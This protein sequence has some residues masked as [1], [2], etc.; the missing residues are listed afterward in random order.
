MIRFAGKLLMLFPLYA[1]GL[2]VFS[3]ISGAAD[4]ME[5]AIQGQAK[6]ICEAGLMVKCQ[7]RPVSFL[8]Y[9]E[10]PKQVVV[11]YQPAKGDVRSFTI[12]SP[13]GDADSFSEPGSSPEVQKEMKRLGIELKPGDRLDATLVLNSATPLF[14]DADAKQKLPSDSDG[15][16]KNSGSGCS[17]TYRIPRII[18]FNNK[19]TC[20]A[21]IVCRGKP[22]TTTSICPANDSTSCP[23]V[24]T[25]LADET[26]H[27]LPGQ[28]LSVFCL[29]K[30]GQTLSDCTLA[31][32]LAK[33]WDKAPPS[34]KGDSAAAGSDDDQKEPGGTSEAK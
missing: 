30:R 20:A 24:D 17:Y 6:C 13:S 7:G 26:M 21:L 3:P 15:P 33:S 19:K 5:C 32:V 18:D 31:G 23:D 22:G 16:S 1:F 9:S 8:R 14:L 10:N 27:Q 12:S 4:T 28:V 29:D 34:K 11:R 2:V 25:C